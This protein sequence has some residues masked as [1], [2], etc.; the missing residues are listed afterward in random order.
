MFVYRVTNL[1]NGK[2]YVGKSKNND[3]KYFGSGPLIKEAIKKYGIENFQKEILAECDTISD[4]NALEQH[5]IKELKSTS[6]KIGYNLLIGGDGGDTF[7]I[8]SIESQ[9]IT[10]KKLQ[11]K[12]S[13]PS[14]KTREKHRVNTTNLWKDPNFRQR[15]LSRKKEVENTPEHKTKFSKRMK[16]V[17][18]IPENRLK[19]S[20]NSR[21]S[22]NSQWLGYAELYDEDLQLVKKFDCIKHLFAEYPV[23]HKTRMNLRKTNQAIIENSQKRIYPYAGYTIKINKV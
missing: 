12:S 1:I 15:V 10:R 18:S 14:E 20:L 17:C 23:S 9:N 4:L 2:I 5:W 13:Q 22:N 6:R 3:P 16:E 19:R 11:N 21:G 8:R 7:S